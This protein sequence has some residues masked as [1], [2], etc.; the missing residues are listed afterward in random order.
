M[1]PGAIGCLSP[2]QLAGSLWELGVR[3]GV[4]EDRPRTGR[5]AEAEEGLGESIH[6]TGGAYTNVE[7]GV[8][9]LE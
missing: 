4:G 5:E 6:N 2:E 9:E 1:T 7:E 8:A 3:R